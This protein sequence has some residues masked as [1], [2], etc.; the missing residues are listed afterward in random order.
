MNTPTLT[1][2]LDFKKALGGILPAVALMMGTATAG[3]A[4][5]N[6]L[7]TNAQ[8]QIDDVNPNTAYNIRVSYGK[9]FPFMQEAWNRD[10]LEKILNG[11]SN[12]DTG[13]GNGRT[14][15]AGR[16][17]TTGA[18]TAGAGTGNSAGGTEANIKKSKLTTEKDAVKVLAYDIMV[19]P[20]GQ[21]GHYLPGADPLH[22]PQYAS[23]GDSLIQYE[24]PKLEAMD[25]PKTMRD[26]ELFQ[27]CFY[28]LGL[29]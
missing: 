16:N 23:Q 11:Q 28:T 4:A 21:P 15:G 10:T 13:D 9:R 22:Q 26:L 2:S 20:F 24:Q 27:N 18:A 7:V 14:A 12:G 5:P 17:Q 8:G 19:K 29:P 6:D 1:K 25:Q 3:F